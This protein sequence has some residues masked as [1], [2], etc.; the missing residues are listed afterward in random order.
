M[1]W[2]VDCYRRPLQDDAGQPLWE[3]VICDPQ[4]A[5]C[6]VS[7]FCPQAEVT[8]DWL[9]RQLERVISETGGKPER[10]QVFRPAS[11]NLVE[12]AGQ[13]LAVPVEA[14]RRTLALKSELQV[15]AR[16]YSQM[17]GYTGESYDP[18]LIERPPP[19]PLPEDL[20]GEQWRFV[21]LSASDLEEVLVQRPMPIQEISQELLPSQQ[22]LAESALI[23]GLVIDSGRRSMQLARW[24]REQQP[25]F[26]QAQATGV[27]LEVG[28][29]D[30]K[31]LFTYDDPGMAAA[32]QLFT[33]RQQE[34][35][36]IHFLLVQPD[37]SGVTYTGLWLLL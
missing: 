13:A 28:I 8:A 2:Q 23:P 29:C 3:L 12:A 22:G 30:R 26:L 31:V 24:L 10:L 36:G 6:Q 21:A 37:N 1:P 16:Q 34:S 19:Q 25:V 33:Q 18:L 20:L 17:P 5:S 32:A 7:V 9:Q 11:L 27:V 35:Q 4:D 15:R 14:T